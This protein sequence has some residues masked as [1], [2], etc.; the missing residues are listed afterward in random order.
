MPPQLKRLSEYR[1][2][3]VSR[4]PVE[5]LP[6]LGEVEK[7]PFM[8]GWSYL[9]TA[10]SKTGKTEL[11]I[12]LVMSWSDHTI[13]WITEEGEVMWEKRAL[14]LGEGGEN[15][16]M[17]HAIGLSPKEIAE[18][19]NQTEWDVLVIDTIKLL[20]I[21]DENDPAEVM[22]RLRPLLAKQQKDRKMSIFLHHSRKAGGAHGMAAAG[23][24]AFQGAVDISLFIDHFPTSK[25]HRLLHGLGR[26]YPVEDII[27]ALEGTELIVQE[28]VESVPVR[29]M[30][31]MTGD[32]QSTKELSSLLDPEPGDAGKALKIL[33]RQKRVERK[34]PLDEGTTQGGTYYWT[35][36]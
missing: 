25:K 30:E 26:I 33:A 34:P 24:G 19:V 14:Y 18:V 11:M 16:M 1:V 9:L 28:K 17:C 15:V 22:K 31:V 21:V 5:R 10:Y 4:P 8:E 3:A 12:R 29:L 35:V 13:L 27:Y 23:S 7:S 32:W 2:L 36:E 6:F 20:Q